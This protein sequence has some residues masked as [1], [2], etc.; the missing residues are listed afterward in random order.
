VPSGPPA[1]LVLGDPER[2][3]LLAAELVLNRLAARPAK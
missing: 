1:P 3:G 2:I